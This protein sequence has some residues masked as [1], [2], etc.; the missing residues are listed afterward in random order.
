MNSVFE[1]KNYSNYYTNWKRIIS[2]IFLFIFGF[3][4]LYIIFS[5]KSMNEIFSWENLSKSTRYSPFGIFSTV[6]ASLF[7]L[8]LL[9]DIINL[10]LARGCFFSIKSGHLFFGIRPILLISEIDFDKSYVD[11][12]LINFFSVTRQ[13][14]ISIKLRYLKYDRRNIIGDLKRACSGD[15]A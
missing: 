3:L 12:Y 1:M 2:D 13:G 9:K 15:V 4:A 11:D 7:V 6:G 14:K 5:N 10:T 8:W